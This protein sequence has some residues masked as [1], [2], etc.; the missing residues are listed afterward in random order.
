MALLINIQVAKIE[1][2][3]RRAIPIM[4]CP[5]VQ[6]FP[7]FVP[8]PTNKPAMVYKTIEGVINEEEGSVGDKIKK[9]ITIPPIKSRRHKK[10]FL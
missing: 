3:D 8:I 6:P 9:L 7:S 2:F 5:L 10:S 4:P 1:R